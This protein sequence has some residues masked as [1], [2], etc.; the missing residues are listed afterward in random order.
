MAATILLI[1]AVILI[2]L[3]CL[4]VLW[5]RNPYARLHFVGPATILGS[6]GVLAAVLTEESSFQGWIKPIL[7]V[8]ALLVSG[9]ITSHAT[10]RAIYAREAHGASGKG[11]EK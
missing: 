9:P 10:A 7:I 1:F 5:G 11:R 3:C 2:W 6:L 4:G 8:V